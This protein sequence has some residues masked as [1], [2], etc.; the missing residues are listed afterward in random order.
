MLQVHLLIQMTLQAIHNDHD[1]C[2]TLSYDD[3]QD[4]TI[5]DGIEIVNPI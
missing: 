4:S 3:L 1:V 5:F 2:V